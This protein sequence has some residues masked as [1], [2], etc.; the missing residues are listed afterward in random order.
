MSQ[1]YNFSLLPLLLLRKASK[2]V[3]KGGDKPL[4]GDWPVVGLLLNWQYILHKRIQEDT[5]FDDNSNRKTY[6]SMS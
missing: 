6:H 2:A 1:Y 5:Y 4:C 3:I